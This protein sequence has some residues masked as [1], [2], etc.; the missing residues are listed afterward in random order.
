[1]SSVGQVEMAS[2]RGSFWLKCFAFL[3]A[4]FLVNSS[5]IGKF[6]PQK[7][8]TGMSF[9]NILNQPSSVL[10]AR[11]SKPIPAN[12]V[13]SILSLALGF[14]V[15]KEISWK[16]LLSGNP[17]KRPDAALLV[18]VDS[19]P[20]GKD[21]KVPAV[22]SIEVNSVSSEESRAEML[23]LSN[24]RTLSTHLSEAYDGK[25]YTLSLSANEDLAAAGYSEGENSQ[26]VL[27]SDEKNS[28]MI[29]NSKHPKGDILFTKD[30][31]LG[32]MQNI[33]KGTDLKFY[34]KTNQ[35]VVKVKNDEVKFDLDVKADFMFFSELA[36]TQMLFSK[37]ESS[38]YVVK[39][40]AADIYMIGI[41]TLKDLK[42]KYGAKSL[43]VQAAISVLEKFIPEITE[44]FVK[45][46]N[47]N[48]LAVQLSLEGSDELASSEIQHNEK[49]YNEVKSHLG[50]HGIEDFYIKFQELHVGDK[51]ESHVKRALCEHMS[52]VLSGFGV[53]MKF[54]CSD[55]SEH[56]RTSRSLLAASKN[57]T[58]DIDTVNLASNY[59]SD[60]PII[61]NLWF[62]LV[63]VLFLTVYVISLVMW[64]MDPGSDSII[65]RMT[66]QRMK[67]E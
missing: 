36:V 14:S 47:G 42:A 35:I 28:W 53:D 49:I 17:F 12:E 54:K 51:V 7:L 31:V 29:L 16:G 10:L 39:D 48:A 56:R 21:L 55:G 11:D 65:Y 15:P 8:P 40:G 34:P 46:Y 6:V 20:N 59:K 52:G 57:Q 66:N 22:K 62:W 30:L 50:K 61:F 9:L 5:L 18:T 67:T 13:T 60:F 33:F 37:I 3:S 45:L 1:L 4:G 64:Y 32:E 41:S 58:I 25:A 19:V 27:W 38:S 63:V 24:L 23:S 43:Q 44:K 26:T 2:L